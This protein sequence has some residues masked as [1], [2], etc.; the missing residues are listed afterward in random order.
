MQKELAA[1]VTMLCTSSALAIPAAGATDHV[2][3][4]SRASS[5]PEVTRSIASRPHGIT[6]AA[7]GPHTAGATL[8]G[9]F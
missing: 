3:A 6:T 1:L 9:R 8:T 2:G 5:T 7:V 4:E